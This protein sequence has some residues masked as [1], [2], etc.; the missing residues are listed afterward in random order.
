M[1][2]P[3]NLTHWYVQSEAAKARAAGQP[4]MATI[5]GGSMATPPGHLDD[6]GRS[7]EPGLVKPKTMRETE[8]ED[9]AT[10]LSWVWRVPVT[11][12]TWSQ[13]PGTRH[14]LRTGELLA[15]QRRR[16]A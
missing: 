7:A 10:G 5:C 3:H 16:L 8:Y 15:R 11:E 2:P 12:S 1:G 4:T 6:K 13:S 9:A 14:R